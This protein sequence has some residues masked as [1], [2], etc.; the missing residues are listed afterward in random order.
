MIEG[1][2]AT[3]SSQNFLRRLVPQLSVKFLPQRNHSIAG[4]QTAQAASVA[5]TG[6]PR[7]PLGN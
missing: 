2:L 4:M 6:I 3:V 7:L 1:R 5:D